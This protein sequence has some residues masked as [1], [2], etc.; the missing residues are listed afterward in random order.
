M[1]YYK[2]GRHNT[3]IIPNTLKLKEKSL[4]YDKS[5]LSSNAKDIGT[6][7]LIFALFSGLI[8]TAFSVLIRLEL[9][10]SGVQYIADNQLYSNIIAAHAIVM[11]L[12]FYTPIVILG[13]I[14]LLNRTSELL[15]L[16]CNT[17]AKPHRLVNLKL[18]SMPVGLETVASTINPYIAA[19]FAVVYGCYFAYLFID[20]YSTIPEVTSTIPVVTSTIP[21]LT[22]TIP[23]VPSILPLQS[24]LFAAYNREELFMIK[25]SGLRAQ[26]FDLLKIEYL[27]LDLDEYIRFIDRHQLVYPELNRLLVTFPG[28]RAH[29]AELSALIDTLN[30]T[31]AN[32]HHIVH[33]DVQRILT[34]I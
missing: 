33:N 7:Y 17:P 8:G 3:N 20:H 19:G 11:I 23:V 34:Q 9:S 30:T 22:T 27:K 14:V 28:G 16:Y 29:I 21:E 12:L 1:F 15:Q 6:L 13:F 2:P 18:T 10:V 26:L 24:E 32:G 25:M 5:G 4:E 31:W